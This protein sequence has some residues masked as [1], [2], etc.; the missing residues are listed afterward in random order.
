MI[1]LKQCIERTIQALCNEL[2]WGLRSFYAAETLYNTELRLTPTLFDTF[3]WSCLD[4]SALILSRL[5]VTKLK[6]ADSINIPYLLKQAQANPELFYYAESGEIENIVGK[7][8][9]LIES[10]K[11]VIDVLEEQRDRNLAHLDR[12]HVNRP[13]WHENQTKLDL[14]RIEQLFKDLIDVMNDYHRLFFGGEFNFDKWQATSI[15]EV[16]LLIA[17]YE[18]YQGNG[19]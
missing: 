12:K 10:Y 5:I 9:E 14:D 16:E 17:F 8:R 4:Q 15:E 19:G 3:Y 13:D 1:T 2:D 7:H 11:S 18:A 6:N